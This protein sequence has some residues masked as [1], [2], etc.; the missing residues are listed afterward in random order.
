MSDLNICM[1]FAVANDCYWIPSL[2]ARNETGMELGSCRGGML[3]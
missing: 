1:L 3:L 2:K